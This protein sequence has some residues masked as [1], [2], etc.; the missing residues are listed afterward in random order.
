MTVSGSCGRFNR[1]VLKPSSGEVLDEVKTD[2]S[3]RS[4]EECQGAVKFSNP[5][6]AAVDHLIAQS[7][8]V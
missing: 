3:S 8:E 2:E 5:Y 7:Q 4:R 1:I 6:H